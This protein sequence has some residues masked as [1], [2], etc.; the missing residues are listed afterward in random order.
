M[1]R[2]RLYRVT[3]SLPIIIVL[4]SIS[5]TFLGF[6]PDEIGF[7]VGTIT[8][9][10]GILLQCLFSLTFACPQCGKSPYA[11]GP[12]IGPFALAGKPIPDAQC[13]NC[14]YDL[15]AGEQHGVEHPAESGKAE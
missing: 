14:G 7:D 4:G 9:S 8:F 15:V 3:L 12:S 2:V 11:V 10:F 5:Y 13:S 6:G 1:I